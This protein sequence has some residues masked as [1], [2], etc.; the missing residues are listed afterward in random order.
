MES[1]VKYLDCGQIYRKSS[2]DVMNFEVKKLYD[3]TEKIIPFFKKYPLQGIK[4]LE[5]ENLFSVFD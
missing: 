4:K 1:L 5:F 2:I 3:L